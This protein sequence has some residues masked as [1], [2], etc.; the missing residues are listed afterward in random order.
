MIGFKFKHLRELKDKKYKHF[1]QRM[2]KL[3]MKIFINSNTSLDCL[4]SKD[5]VLHAHPNLLENMLQSP[6]LR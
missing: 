6:L 3:I 1:I 5:M 2:N 4:H